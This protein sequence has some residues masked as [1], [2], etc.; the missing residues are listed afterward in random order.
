MCT[1]GRRILELPS[2]AVIMLRRFQPNDVSEDELVRQS[3]PHQSLAAYAC[4]TLKSRRTLFVVD[5]ESF[6]LA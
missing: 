5:H 6:D 2:W 3:S 4:N 1:A